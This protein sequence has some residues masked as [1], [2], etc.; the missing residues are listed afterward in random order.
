M[1]KII[2]HSFI[3]IILSLTVS[4]ALAQNEISNND[5]MQE[6]E[7]ILLFNDEEKS[8][9]RPTHSSIKQKDDF[10]IGQEENFDETESKFDIKLQKSNIIINADART[11]ERCWRRNLW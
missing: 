6:I 4:K 7:Q 10:T 8:R 3:A 1:L 11:K 5:I 2:K 9:L